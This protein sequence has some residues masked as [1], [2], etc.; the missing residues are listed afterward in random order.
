[1]D[2]SDFQEGDEQAEQLSGDKHAVSNWRAMKGGK[3]HR[4]T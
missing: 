1:M 3:A 2:S 4:G